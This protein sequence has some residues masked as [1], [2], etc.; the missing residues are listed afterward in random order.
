MFQV[1]YEII[2]TFTCHIIFKNKPK[3]KVFRKG[4]ND[5]GSLGSEFSTTFKATSSGL[6]YQR[7][8]REKRE[9]KK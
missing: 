3:K 5:H 9:R 6:V 8:D 2:K 4:Y 7:T 1:L